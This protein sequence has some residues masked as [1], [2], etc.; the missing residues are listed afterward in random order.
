V[1]PAS[2][3]IDEL[4]GERLPGD[5]LNALQA[6]VSRLRRA[7]GEPAAVASGPAGYQLKAGRDDIDV[8]R[9]EELTARGRAALSAPP[10]PA[11]S[12][13]RAC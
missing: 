10:R 9:F 8:F 5:A 3:L 2:S 12:A 6:L 11:R 1:V 13:W 4:R 7:T